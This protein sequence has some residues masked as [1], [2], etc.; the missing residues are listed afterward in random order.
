[1]KKRRFLY[2]GILLLGLMALAVPAWTV[3]YDGL[4][5][6]ILLKGYL[7]SASGAAIRSPT[8]TGT[9]GTGAILPSQQIIPLPL[10][11]AYIVGTGIM[12]NDGTTAPGIATT[13]GIP[14]IV[15]ANSNEASAASQQ[16]TFRVPANYSSGLGFRFWASTSSATSPPKV[17]WRLLVNGDDTAFATTWYEQT[18]VQLGADSATKNDEIT[19]TPAAT[20]LAAIAAGK[21]VTLEI[22]RDDYG[23]DETLEIANI[24]AFFTA[25][26]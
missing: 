14:K 7:D 3:Y 1:M 23:L 15:W 11:E 16:W 25:K 5:T 4:F 6:N 9:I 24:H 18:V 22:C 17:N 19:L 12:G 21:V 2:A 13:D 26:Q 8:I 20:A 10:T